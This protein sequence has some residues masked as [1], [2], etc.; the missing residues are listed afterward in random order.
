MI[1]CPCACTAHPLASSP[2]QVVKR[3]IVLCYGDPSKLKQLADFLRA[4]KNWSIRV[5][6]L[7]SQLAAYWSVVSY[8]GAA[9]VTV[10]ARSSDDSPRIAFTAVMVFTLTGA[11][12]SMRTMNQAYK[13]I[14]KE[15]SG[16][17]GNL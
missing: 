2:S 3:L 5:P 7:L 10:W 12:I 6:Y 16:L 9:V 8:G 15:L 14:K 17:S 4:K 1:S 13:K 11:L